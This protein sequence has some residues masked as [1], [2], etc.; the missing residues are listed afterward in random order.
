VDRQQSA[1]SWLK[2]RDASLPA[3]SPWAVDQNMLRVPAGIS[4]V[5]LDTPGGLQ[6]FELARVV[7]FADVIIM[8]ICNSMFDLESAAN[9]HAELMTLPRVASGRCRLAS[10]GMRIDGRTHAAQMLRKWSEDHQVPFLGTLRETQQYVR[11]LERGMTIFDLPVHAAATDLQQW[12]PILQ[13]LA[14]L[15]YPPQAA[16]DN[17]RSGG[18]SSV[19]ASLLPGAKLGSALPASLMPAQ[20]SLVHGARLTIHGPGRM[21]SRPVHSSEQT[22]QDQQTSTKAAA[23]P[24][25]RPADTPNGLQIPA[26]LRRWT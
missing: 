16:N 14:P 25:A 8:P 9:C 13:W 22:S 19:A 15:L 26:F 11:T 12:E 4:H 20:E 6:G 21:A 18:S 3:I 10:V 5:V 1:R 7:M 23:S 17:L 2:R 24:L